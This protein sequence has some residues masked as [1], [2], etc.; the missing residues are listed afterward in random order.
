V[1][2]RYLF[3]ISRRVPLTYT[4]M[5]DSCE[6]QN[7]IEIILDRRHAE[8]RRLAVPARADRRGHERRSLKIDGLLKQLGW[9][10]I[11]REAEGL[12]DGQSEAHPT[13]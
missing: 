3:I 13:S 8:R 11:K 5:K 10:F 4:T 6:G 2:N 7:D 1:A 9:V 12:P